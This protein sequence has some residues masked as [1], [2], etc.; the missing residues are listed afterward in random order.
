MQQAEVYA[1]HNRARISPK[2]V[3][4]VMD[5]IRGKSLS[6][7]KRV[8]AFDT[9]KAA[10]ML[11]KVLKS[12]EANASNNKNLRPQDLYVS[13]VHVSGSIFRKTGRAGS[14]GRFDPIIKRN[15]NIV[16]GLSRMESAAQPAVTSADDNGEEN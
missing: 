5:L 15:S 6:E 8:L 16:L 7:A 3:R 9:T 1:K 4:V 13:E 11:L 10:S 12:A 2:K 14:K